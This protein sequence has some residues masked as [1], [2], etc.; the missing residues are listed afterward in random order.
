MKK[1]RGIWSTFQSVQVPDKTLSH[2]VDCRLPF[3]CT[4]L[5]GFSGLSGIIATD[6]ALTYFHFVC[7]G[8]FK[9]ATGGYDYTFYLAG[10]LILVSAILCYPLNMVNEWEKRRANRDE[11]EQDKQAVARVV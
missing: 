6:L 1:L 4:T 9:A 8:A 11:E 10:A 2:R 3:K 5:A 7:A